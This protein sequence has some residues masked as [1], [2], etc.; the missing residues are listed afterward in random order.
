MLTM[1]K[2]TENELRSEVLELVQ[3]LA[4]LAVENYLR[5]IPC[6][7]ADFGEQ[8]AKPALLQSQRPAA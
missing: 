8:R 5:E 2:A 1:S 7:D 4:K 3:A 6:Q